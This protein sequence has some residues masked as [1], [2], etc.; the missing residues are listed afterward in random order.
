MKRLTLYTLTTVAGFV[1]GGALALQMSGLIGQRSALVFA[2]VNVDGW[3]SD[4][5]ISSAS[6]DGYTRARVA[7]HGLLALSKTEAV[8]FTRKTDNNGE[9]LRETCDYAL[10]GGAQ[11]ALWWSIT[12]YDAQSRLP[13]NSDK[14]LSI[15]ATQIG[16]NDSW[17][18]VISK[19]RPDV[20]PWISSRAAGTFDLTL[21]L[22]RPDAD[23]I[24]NPNAALNAPKLSK[25]KCEGEL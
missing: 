1:L 3:V 13:A 7:R 9:T 11:D 24:D 23:I 22:Y 19:T 2:D 12:L 16:R 6:A 8:Y 21:R 10:T 18:A 25:L 5:S 20:G 14:A 15:D 4:W 17:S